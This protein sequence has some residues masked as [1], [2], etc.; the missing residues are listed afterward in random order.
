MTPQSVD[1]FNARLAAS[2]DDFVHAC[3]SIMVKSYELRAVLAAAGAPTDAASIA[4]DCG[5]YTGAVR[6]ARELR[7]RY[8][9]L[10]LA[11]DAC[12]PDRRMRM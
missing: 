2:W 12:P 4:L 9:F 6:H 11:A 5:F 3:E 8:T 1:G 10:D 7:N